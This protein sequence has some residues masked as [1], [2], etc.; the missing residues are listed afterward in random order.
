MSIEAFRMLYSHIMLMFLEKGELEVAI[1][2]IHVSAYE[3]ELWLMLTGISLHTQCL[4]E[5]QFFQRP[6]F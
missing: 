4:E 3:A 5:H 1:T 2:D 6:S